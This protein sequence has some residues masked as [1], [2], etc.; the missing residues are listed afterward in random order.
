MWRS[1]YLSMVNRFLI[2]DFANKEDLYI[3]FEIE[4]DSG[5]G[6]FVSRGIRFF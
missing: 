3:S 4:N 6:R 5:P 1:V 2:S